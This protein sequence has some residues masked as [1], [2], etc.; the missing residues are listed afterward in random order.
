MRDDIPWWHDPARIA[1]EIERCTTF[2]AIGSVVTAAM[3]VILAAL[4]AQGA[5]EAAPLPETRS[6]NTGGP[7]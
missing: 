3:P 6:E 7:S 4:K 2:A 1:D 5:A